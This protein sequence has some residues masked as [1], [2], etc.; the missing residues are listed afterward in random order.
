M[1]NAK[2]VWRLV[3]MLLKKDSSQ[4]IDKVE[5]S[6]KSNSKEQDEA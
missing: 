5:N 2:L 1:N 3:E 4:E 6:N